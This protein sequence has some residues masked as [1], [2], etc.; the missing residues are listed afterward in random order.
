MRGSESDA[1]SPLPE[2]PAMTAW[3][4]IAAFPLGRKVG[5]L[6]SIS[7]GIGKFFTVGKLMALA[8]IPVSVGLFFWRLAPWVARRYVLTDR[9]VVIR[10]GLGG[11]EAEAIALKDF[12]SIAVEILIGQEFLRAG[13]LVFQ[14]SGK[15]VFRLAGVQHPQGFRQACL[16]GQAALAS[17]ERVVGEQ[18]KQAEAVAAS[19]NQPG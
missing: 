15:E 5:Q 1:E 19:G 17:V 4:S 10:N 6:C 14:S 13:D 9:R 18:A 11:V 3:P 12:D 8:T 7:A 16:R 2:I